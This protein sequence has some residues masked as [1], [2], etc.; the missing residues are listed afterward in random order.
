MSILTLGN[1][2]MVIGPVDMVLT[3]TQLEGVSGNDTTRNSC[4]NFIHAIFY[5]TS[6]LI[7]FCFFDTNSF[8]PAMVTL[9]VVAS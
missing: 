5:V 4:I 6:I 3:A 7:L 9:C 1:L 8:L 2:A